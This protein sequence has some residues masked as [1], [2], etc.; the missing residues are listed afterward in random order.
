MRV[1]GAVM[2]AVVMMLVIMTM[3]IMRMVMTAAG[4]VSMRVPVLVLVI[5]A[6]VVV[7]IVMRL[8]VI[9][10]VMG[11]A[12]VVPAATGRVMGVVLLAVVLM[13]VVLM[14]VVVTMI[15]PV[16]VMAVMIMAAILVAMIIGAALGLERALDLAHRAALAADHLGEDMV[17]LDIDRIGGDL[18][19]GV[20][21][22]DMPGDAHQA[23]RVLGADLEQALRRGLDQD[24]AT[25]LQLDRVAVVQCGRLVEIEQNVEPAIAL[26]RDAAAVAV[27]MVEGQRLD[28]LVLLDR[29]LAGDGG[30][31]QHD[32]EPVLDD[33]R[34]STDR[35]SITSITGGSVTQAPA[36]LRKLR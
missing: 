4:A 6:M 20:A 8:P 17:V 35:G 13:G 12:V 26:E 34:R 14:G 30:G 28:D 33:Q 16:V 21:V 5:M 32:R 3:V 27:L 31:A 25:I 2:M 18:G 19:R 9:M 11:M 24:E 36:T 10:V 23:Q 1:L 29:G 22:A 7:V 15:V